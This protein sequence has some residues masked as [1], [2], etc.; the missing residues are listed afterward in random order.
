MSW[1]RENLFIR[2]GD[3]TMLLF[4]AALVGFILGALYGVAGCG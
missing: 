1:H 4:G 3:L 2:M